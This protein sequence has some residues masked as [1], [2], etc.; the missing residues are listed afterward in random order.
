MS[1]DGS[2]AYAADPGNGIV[3]VFD[4]SG[5]P[6]KILGDEKGPGKLRGPIAVAEAPDKRIFVIDRLDNRLVIFDKEGNYQED[7]RPANMPANF[8]LVPIA[9]AF[10]REG[11]LYLGDGNGAVYIFDKD[12]NLVR[13]LTPPEGRFEAPWG[14]AVNAAGQVAVTDSSHQRV[15]VFRP[16]GTVQAILGSQGGPGA[17]SLPRG[18]AIDDQGRVF[19]A[20]AFAHRVQVYSADGQFLGY[21]GEE[22]NLD[23]QLSYPDG[24]AVDNQGNLYVADRGNKRVQVWRY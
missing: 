2:R 22:G 11:T 18:V 3:T 8:P 21:F 12:G 4:R 7:F 15:F 20:D 6:L 14:V 17:L 19:V 16:D 23:G 13:R 24:V 10:D 5:K 1:R 9:L